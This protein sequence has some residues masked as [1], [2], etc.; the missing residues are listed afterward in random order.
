[1]GGAIQEI[2]WQ[3]LVFVMFVVSRRLS[4]HVNCWLLVGMSSYCGDWI[5]TSA[6]LSLWCFWCRV[7]EAERRD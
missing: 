5:H 7:A 6:G 4:T 3:L 1:M 2:V